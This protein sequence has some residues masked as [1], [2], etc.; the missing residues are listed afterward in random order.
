MLEPPAVKAT[1]SYQDPLVLQLP[2]QAPA[3]LGR[4]V[5]PSPGGTIEWLAT[6]R[7]KKA[8]AFSFAYPEDLFASTLTPVKPR[9]SYNGCTR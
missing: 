6:Y 4:G 3:F 8:G 2:L 5:T 1:I 7:P 9:I